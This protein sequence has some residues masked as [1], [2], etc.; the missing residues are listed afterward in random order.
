MTNLRLDCDLARDARHSD[1]DKRQNAVAV[2]LVPSGPNAGNILLHE[3]VVDRNF[4]H[5]E[6]HACIVP[7]TILINQSSKIV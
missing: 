3:L 4:L 2:T 1:V 5:D 6:F 7:E